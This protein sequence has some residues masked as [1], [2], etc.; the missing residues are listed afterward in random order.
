MYINLSNYEAYTKNELVE[1]DNKIK[2][3]FRKR[4]IKESFNDTKLPKGLKT[5]RDLHHISL[6]HLQIIEGIIASDSLD[7]IARLKLMAQ[8]VIRPEDE[9]NILNNADKEKEDIHLKLLFE[10]NIGSI[11]EAVTAYNTLRGDYLY[12]RFNGVLY[13]AKRDEEVVDDDS[14]SNNSAQIARAA[15]EKKFFWYKINMMV[16]GES[17]F[18]VQK[19]LNLPLS[20]V[21]PMLAEKRSEAIVANLEQIAKK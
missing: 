13:K 2:E 14:S 18:N 16:A 17:I 5:I 11:F 20:K 9:G 12:K 1:E 19:A 21:M 6:G 15:H 7:N 4:D 10:A 8:F 3:V